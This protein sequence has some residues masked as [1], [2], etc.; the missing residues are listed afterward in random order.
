MVSGETADKT[1][2]PSPAGRRQ[3]YRTRDKFSWEESS[4]VLASQQNSLSRVLIC[5]ASDGWGT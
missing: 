5:L 2:Q 1:E 3:Q 4:K